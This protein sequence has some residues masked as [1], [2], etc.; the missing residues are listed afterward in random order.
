MKNTH[1]A[2]EGKKQGKKME[3]E[4]CVQLVYEEE[5]EAR[6]HGSARDISSQCEEDHEGRLLG[7]SFWFP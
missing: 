7:S 6:T 2:E 4:R 5:G 1:R 3:R